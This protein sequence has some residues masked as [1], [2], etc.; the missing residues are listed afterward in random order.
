MSE[1]SSTEARHRTPLS[2]RGFLGLSALGLGVGLG[3]AAWGPWPGAAVGATT[4]TD[5]E[6]LRFVV[7][8]DTHANEEEAAR[9][10]NLRRVFAAVDAEQPQFV[11]HC[12][13]IT[14]YGSDAGF[15]A[16]RDTIPAGLWDRVRHVP[17]NHEIRWDTSARER[18]QRWF[19]PTSYSFDAGGVHFMAL[20]PTQALQ[21]PGLF[22]DDLAALRD[23]LAEAAGIPSIMFL[24]YPL[25]GRNYFVNDTDELLRTIEPFPV[26]G[27]FAGH[28]HRHEVDRFNGLTQV[29]ST[30]TRGGPFY[31]RVTERRG[32]QGRV[33]VVENVTLGATDAEAATVVLLTEIPLEVPP[34]GT[35]PIRGAVRAHP[36]RID[37]TAVAGA[38]AVAVEARVYPQSVF[39]T[40]DDGTWTPLEPRGSSWHGSLDAAALAPGAHRVQLRATDAQGVRRHETVPVAVDGS[41]RTRTAW[42]LRVGGQLQGALAASGSTVVAGSTSGRVVAVDI[43]GASSYRPRWRV[44]LGPVHRGAAFTTDGALVVVPSAD[45]RLTALDA[46]TGVAAWTSDL[47]KPVMSTPLVVPAAGGDR[48]LV[49]AEDRLRCLDARG[50]TL[51]EAD[52]P[53]R[54]AGRA[55][56]DGARVYVGAGDGRGY[57]YDLSSGAQLWSFLTN[58]RPDKYRQ[59]IYG[60]WDDWVEVLSSG[61]VLFSTVTDAIAVDPVTGAELWRVPGSHIFAPAVALPDGGLLLT[62]EWGVVS[63]VDPATGVVR[64]STTAVPRVV[65]AGPVLDPGTGTVWLAS[66]GGLLAAIDPAAGTVATDRQLFT[67]NT[68]STPVVVGRQLVVAAQDGVLRGLSI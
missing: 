7:V 11:L 37:L 39:G 6:G 55:A 32:D 66:V 21:E 67:A 65:N 35:V 40:I 56:S 24:H 59:L 49:A 8:T 27:I 62:T 5:P 52:V 47:G 26:R 12:G 23:D 13:D 42:E 19:G 50:K 22:G 14:D 48:I 36:G 64:W 53:V 33:L 18:F 46:R 29:A 44:D 15:A 3:G 20:D 10:E 57:A 61:A 16:Y 38:A 31:L 17:G 2:R 25:A 43:T 4:E 68:F 51:W 34:G 28:I 30:A 54:T 60:P 1:D 9:L 45:H 58:T 63:V 41:P